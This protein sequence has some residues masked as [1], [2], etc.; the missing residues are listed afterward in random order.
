MVTD[1]RG[2][3]TVPVPL[4]VVGAS[5]AVMSPIGVDGQVRQINHFLASPLVTGIMTVLFLALCVTVYLHILRG[6]TEWLSSA[7][8]RLAWIALM[9]AIALFIVLSASWRTPPLRWIAGIALGAAWVWLL[10]TV[11]REHIGSAADALARASN[12]RRRREEAEMDV[13]LEQTR[14]R[15]ATLD[16]LLKDALD[17]RE[18]ER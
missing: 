6:S 18:A 12:P 13:P 2:V 11:I 15:G 1:K 16:D 8:R 14:A 10:A 4:Y 7:H 3:V 9:V 17:E 5:I